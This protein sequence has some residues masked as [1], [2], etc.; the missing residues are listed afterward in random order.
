MG[1][2]K[3]LTA[4]NKIG[5]AV[6]HIFLNG[7]YGALG[8]GLL[9]GGVKDA[10]NSLKQMAT[11]EDLTDTEFRVITKGFWDT[12]IT[13]TINSLGGDVDTDFSRRTGWGKGIE[14]YIT[15][16]WDPGKGS[17]F[18][19]VIGGTGLSE[20][21]DFGTGITSALW[22]ITAFAAAGRTA[23]LPAYAWDRSVQL[24]V[25]EISS[26]STAVKADIIWRTG[27]IRGKDG[28]PLMNVSQTQ[29]FLT[30]LGIPDRREG[31]QWDEMYDQMDDK[32]LIA[33]VATKL[34]ALDAQ[35]LTAFEA[36]DRKKMEEV[37]AVKTGILQFYPEHRHKMVQA[38]INHN[39]LESKW[40]KR[41]SDYAI[42]HSGR[43]LDGE[44]NE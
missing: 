32:K 17:T 22:D 31:Q 9:G 16:L 29:A 28:Q 2:N 43:N 36:G 24:V 33:E 30:M 23:Q 35:W 39:N 14:D 18:L 40:T 37:S 10:A 3:R 19:D 12:I 20:A 7:A 44:R 8:V 41:M 34:S 15:K 6:G 38:A 42:S 11:G 26:L 21:V 25:K 1:G 4:G 5:M 27:E 13:G